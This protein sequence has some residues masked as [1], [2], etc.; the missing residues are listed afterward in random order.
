[1]IERSI[2]KEKSDVKDSDENELKG[3]QQTLLDNYTIV[4]AHDLNYGD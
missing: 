2:T 4:D 1:L 3:T